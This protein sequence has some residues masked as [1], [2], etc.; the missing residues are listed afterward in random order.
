MKISAGYSETETEFELEVGEEIGIYISSDLNIEPFAKATEVFD[1]IHITEMDYKIRFL[2][3]HVMVYEGSMFN[4]KS[5]WEMKIRKFDL[6]DSFQRNPV[7]S[8]DFI[9]AVSKD[10]IMPLNND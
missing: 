10:K 1:S 7:E 2:P 8:S 4:E 9:F 5:V 3:G 6:P